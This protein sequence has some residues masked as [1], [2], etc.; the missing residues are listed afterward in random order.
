MAEK[1]FSQ[2]ANLFSWC[3]WSRGGAAPARML[4]LE[5]PQ[6]GICYNLPA[7]AGSSQ[8][9]SQPC[10]LCSF[11]RVCTEQGKV[12]V[13]A[14]DGGRAV[15]HSPVSLWAVSEL[16][17]PS[18][19]MLMG[20]CSLQL[21]WH[22]SCSGR[23]LPPPVLLFL[24][25]GHLWHCL[26]LTLSPAHGPFAPFSLLYFSGTRPHPWSSLEPSSSPSSCCEIPKCCSCRDAGI[27]PPLD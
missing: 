6:W 17:C 11:T 25:F 20:P 27:S 2:G 10:S 18:L 8:S 19:S 14:G 16:V 4:S 12:E 23:F 22:R 13:A 5:G 21:S 26:I 15:R 7:P 3:S 1:L 9:K 24:I